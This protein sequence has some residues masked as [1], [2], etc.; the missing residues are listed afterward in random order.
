MEHIVLS[1]KFGENALI[2]AASVNN[3]VAVA[4]LLRAGVD[5]RA[6]NDHALWN[7]VD[8]Y[9]RWCT[10]LLLE[11]GADPNSHD[12]AL[13][14]NAA[15]RGDPQTVGLLL[16]YGAKPDAKGY[17]ALKA[18]A[19]HLGTANAKVFDFILE[20]ALKAVATP[21]APAPSVDNSLVSPEKH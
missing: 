6:E 18:A 10:E 12:G 21:A 2:S 19:A 16:R 9:S 20:A 11:A 17:A 4:E 15:A 3:Y 7:A 14:I 13:L 5:A 1:K 8:R